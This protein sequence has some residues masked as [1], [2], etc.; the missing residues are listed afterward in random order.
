MLKS[1]TVVAN[2]PEELDKLTESLYKS[3]NAD[4]INETLTMN[5]LGQYVC[6][7]T[8]NVPEPQDPVPFG[9]QGKIHRR[10]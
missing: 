1:K 10:G 5:G 4:A 3:Y 8:M 7:V 2:T 6:K 9:K